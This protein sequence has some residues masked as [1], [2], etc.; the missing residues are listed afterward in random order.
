MVLWALLDDVQLSPAACDE[1]DP[2]QYSATR[3]SPARQQALL[4]TEETCA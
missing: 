3:P 2:T 1:L 4:R